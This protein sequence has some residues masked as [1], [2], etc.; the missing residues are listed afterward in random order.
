MNEGRVESTWVPVGLVHPDLPVATP[1]RVVGSDG[2][3]FQGLLGTSVGLLEIPFRGR[4]SSGVKFGERRRGD[5]TRNRYRVA[6]GVRVTN[7]CTL[8]HYPDGPGQ[9][10]NIGL[11]AQG[12]LKHAQLACRTKQ[13]TKI[14]F[15]RRRNLVARDPSP[16]KISGTCGCPPESRRLCASPTQ[17]KSCITTPNTKHQNTFKPD[18]APVAASA[19]Y[20]QQREEQRTKPTNREAWTHTPAVHGQLRA[21]EKI[22]LGLETSQFSSIPNRGTGRT[23]TNAGGQ[24][25]TATQQR[26]RQQRNM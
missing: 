16:V 9:E 11:D 26:V 14:V 19:T 25:A 18:R 21:Q 6:A 15:C 4:K 22:D 12:R 7:H 20:S 23:N 13:R 3:L 1:G 24:H 8:P 5:R 10:R 2:L 17:K